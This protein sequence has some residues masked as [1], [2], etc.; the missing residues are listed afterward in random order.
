[1]IDL[2]DLWAGRSGSP[3]QP[4]WESGTPSPPEEPLPVGVPRRARR[5]RGDDPGDATGLV[6]APVGGTAGRQAGYSLQSSSWSSIRSGHRTVGVLDDQTLK[7]VGRLI[8]QPRWWE[9][10]S[11]SSIA[12][13]SQKGPLETSGRGSSIILGPLVR[14]EPS[15]DKKDLV[16]SAT[17][18][19]KSRAHVLDAIS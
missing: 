17:I 11:K 4:L 19:I 18:P 15:A 9:R 7:V 2:K 1:M 14:M 6:P 13:P 12:P 5:S 16:G 8:R 3:A 10:L